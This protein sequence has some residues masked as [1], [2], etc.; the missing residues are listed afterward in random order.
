MLEDKDRIFTNLYGFQPWT[1]DAAM[2]RGDWDNTKALLDLGPDATR[3]D[4]LKAI[5]GHILAKAV[6]VGRFHR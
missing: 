5:D 4:L 6:M 2:Q 3:A 1:I